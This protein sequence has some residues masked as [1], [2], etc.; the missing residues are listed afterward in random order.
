MTAAL[1]AR[2][3][4]Q[5]QHCEMQLTELREYCRR[6]GWAIAGEY[7]DTGWS[8]AKASRPELDRCM[9]DARLH[10]FECVLVW[11]LDR[12]G[13][14]VANLVASIQELSSLSIR[15]IA[16]TQGIDTD[17]ANPMAKFLLHIM[18][19]FAELEREMIRE[20]VKAGMAA[21][22]HR[23]VRCGRPKAAFDRAKVFELRARGM[24]FRE[25]AVKLKVS[26]GTIGRVLASQ[27]PHS[28][29]SASPSIDK[30]AKR[31]KTP[32]KT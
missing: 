28:A 14:S 12:W 1:Y 22:R 13:R 18:A 9:K 4:T 21:A 16:V 5:D 19:A 31:P 7:V 10:K 17:Q 2:V 26:R 30:T 6:S 24:S 3:S 29:T 20:R 11:K 27:N 25:V 32:S 8:G 15:F 23:G